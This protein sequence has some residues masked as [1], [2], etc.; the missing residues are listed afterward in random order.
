MTRRLLVRKI[1]GALA[2]AIVGSATAAWSADIATPD[3]VG[4][5][6]REAIATLKSAG[7]AYDLTITNECGQADVVFK[8]Q[9]P[10]NTP[11][12]SGAHI[13]LWITR[14]SKIVP[15]VVGK[16]LD[17]ATAIL[18]GQG[19]AIDSRERLLETGD[20]KCPALTPTDFGV[21][22]NIVS[23]LPAAGDLLCSPTVQVF[24]IHR[25]NVGS[26]RNASG[27]CP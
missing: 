10:P 21:E 17:Q 14:G 8:Q 12:K 18:Q 4:H 20:L 5:S 13:L 19:L 23:S 2:F 26:M 11:V 9:P 22:L 7:L 6:K 16:T 1:F 24:R 15:D 3:L 25:I 27:I